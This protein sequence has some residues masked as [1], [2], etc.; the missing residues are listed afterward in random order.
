MAGLETWQVAPV[1]DTLYRI[2]RV[3]NSFEGLTPAISAIG[4]TIEVYGS[5]NVPAALV[6]MALG[7]TAPIDGFEKFAVIP[8]YFSYKVLSGTPVVVLADFKLAEDLGAIA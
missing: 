3:S 6:N 4:G 7:N 8:N 2:D 5:Q 1:A